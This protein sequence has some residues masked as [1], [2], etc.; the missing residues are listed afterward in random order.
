M[1]KL[2]YLLKILCIVYRTDFEILE[3]YSMPTLL[4]LLQAWS[5]FQ[6]AY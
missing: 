3:E 4:P 2:A 6:A 5:A 1:R